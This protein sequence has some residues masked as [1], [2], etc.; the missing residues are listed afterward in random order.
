MI[1]VMA[2]ALNPAVLDQV[3]EAVVGAVRQES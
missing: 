3:M 2:E 1:R